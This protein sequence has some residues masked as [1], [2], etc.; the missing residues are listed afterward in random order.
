MHPAV[1]RVVPCA[2]P[3]EKGAT[4]NQVWFQVNQKL[5]PLI[6]RDAFANWRERRSH[7]H[8]SAFADALDQR[9]QQRTKEATPPSTYLIVSGP[10][11][12]DL[13]GVTFCRA[14]MVS[15][16]PALI[17]LCPQRGWEGSKG[18]VGLLRL[19]PVITVTYPHIKR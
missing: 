5:I 12:P 16:A 14:A 1:P 8:H 4:D 3:R 18:I 7:D 17:R 10:D 15:S 11:D 13:D 2:V 19:L 9:K 6:F